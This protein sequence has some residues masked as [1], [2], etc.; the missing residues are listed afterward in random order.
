MR[1]LIYLILLLTAASVSSCVYEDLQECPPLRITVDILDRNYFN[2]DEVAL[3]A[4]VPDTL[5]LT[6]YFTTI[7]W[8]LR[9]A[10]TGEIVD[11]SGIIP[12]TGTPDCFTPDIDD[13][14]PFGDYVFTVWAGMRSLGPLNDDNSE[15]AFHPD[16]G[17]GRDVFLTNDTIEY[18]YEQPEHLVLLERTKGKL[19]IESVN[20]PE[21]INS[22][23][24]VVTGLYGTDDREFNYSGETVL[25]KEIY[26]EQ[27]GRLVTKTV[28]APSI[29]E[30][31]STISMT[32][33]GPGMTL[34]PK[35]VDLTIHRNELTV[36]RYV[37]V[38]EDDDF[39]IFKLVNDRWESVNR[40]EL[41]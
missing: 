4:R 1:H 34:V 7:Q 10:A 37:W 2:V 20:L 41:D 26:F 11:E 29:D 22:S 33:N 12:L 9:D 38:P 31:S 15:I 3:E 25:D 13:D 30:E 18:S 35:D 16:N 40:M 19:I 39:E 14:L 23:I 17:E 8:T 21:E 24:K 28:V 36:L 27:S 6:S 5:P 32:Y